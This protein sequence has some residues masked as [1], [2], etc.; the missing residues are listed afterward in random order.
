[1]GRTPT[2]LGSPEPASQKWT[3]H[4]GGSLVWFA[5]GMIVTGLVGGAAAQSWL[6]THIEDR[7][8]TS[9]TLKKI[10]SVPGPKGESGNLGPKGDPG[11]PGPKGDPGPQ[12][13]QGIAGVA[14]S[15]AVV[16]FDLPSGCPAGWSAFEAATSRLIIGAVMGRSSTVSTRDMHG[17]SLTAYQYRA[18]GGEETHTLTIA[19]MPAHDHGGGLVGTTDHAGLDNTARGVANNERPL[20]MQ[21]EGKAHNIMSPY[22]ALPYCRKD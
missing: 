2:P 14:P 17:N 1:M 7:L 16:A 9:D 12:G 22:I 5:L 8:K 18:D 10:A 6:D 19:E 15:G 4:L 13:L 11:F 21:G 20:M 3:E